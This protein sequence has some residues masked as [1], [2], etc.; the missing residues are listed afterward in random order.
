MGLKIVPTYWQTHCGDH[1][2][3]H[4]NIESLYYK[5]KA[6]RMIYMNYTSFFKNNMSLKDSL[7]KKSTYCFGVLCRDTMS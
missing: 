1:F 4:T 2:T 7:K 5:P 3:A 6:N